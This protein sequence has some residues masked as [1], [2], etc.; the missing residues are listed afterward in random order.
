MDQRRRSNCPISLVL[1]VC[2]DKWSLLV[3]R[4][5]ILNGKRGYQEFLNSD[6]RISTNI[7]ADRLVR[8]E[9]H[10]LISKSDDPESK[11]QFIY[12]PTEK[13]LDLL[14][15]LF[16]MIRWGVK[17]NP[18]IGRNKPILKRM[19]ENEKGFLRELRAQFKEGNL[20]KS[21]V[22]RRDL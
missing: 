20:I 12:A 5:I 21:P 8:L 16:D 14:P 6:E 1:E 10:G 15:I 3:L 4:D 22:K 18:E 17:Y 9:K 13:G 7:L 19:K 2:G 11:K